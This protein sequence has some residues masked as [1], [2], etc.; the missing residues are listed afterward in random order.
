MLAAEEFYSWDRRENRAIDA[1][2]PSLIQALTTG[3][4]T[5]VRPFSTSL[6]NAQLVEIAVSLCKRS[7]SNVA[8]VGSHDGKTLAF[9]PLFSTTSFIRT[10]VE[11]RRA[12]TR[13]SSPGLA[14]SGGRVAAPGGSATI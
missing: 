9:V 3:C 4:A 11:A 12:R 10:Q 2:C 6:T 13:P 7:D 1:L 8:V 14:W 5:L